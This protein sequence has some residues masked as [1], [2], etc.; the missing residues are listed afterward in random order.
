MNKIEK[1]IE[2]ED[3]KSEE[4][5]DTGLEI[6]NFDDFLVYFKNYVFKSCHEIPFTFSAYL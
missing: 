6:K 3:Q 1:K 2:E 4:K 5:I